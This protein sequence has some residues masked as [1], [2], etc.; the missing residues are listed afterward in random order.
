[1]W[2]KENFQLTSKKN[3]CSLIES[4]I[5]TAQSE[6]E[7]LALVRPRKGFKIQNPYGRKKKK[8]LGVVHTYNPS[9][10]EVGEHKW[11]LQ[12][13]WPASI[14]CLGSSRP[15]TYYLKKERKGCVRLMPII[16]ALE[17]L[18]QEDYQKFEAILN[19]TAVFQN[20]YICSPCHWY[21]YTDTRLADSQGITYTHTCS[22]TTESQA[23]VI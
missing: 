20:I 23:D 11:I 6:S 1:M 14:V 17:I 7:M 9:I 10:R 2:Y 21:T 5:E 12:A 18:R 22:H 19:S 15:V 4:T 13:H 16:P 3:H 8:K